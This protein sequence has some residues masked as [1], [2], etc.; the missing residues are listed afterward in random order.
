MRVYEFS[1]EY[2]ISNKEV[3]Q[4]LQDVGFEVESHM[5]ILTPEQIE[6]LGETFEK[7]EQEES[8]P[9]AARK[10]KILVKKAARSE[11]C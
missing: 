4:A 10:G 1:K 5:A 6:F 2:N 3:L 8:Q 9:R 7:E 11:G